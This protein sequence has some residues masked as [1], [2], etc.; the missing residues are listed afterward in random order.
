VTPTF[1]EGNAMSASVCAAG[2]KPVRKLLGELAIFGALGDRAL[3]QIDRLLQVHHFGAGCLVVCEGHT[4][5]NVFIVESGEVE[6]LKDCSGPDTAS[7]RLAI[8]GPGACFGE[9]SLIDVMP[10]SASVRTTRPSVLLSFSNA[11]LFFIYQ[12]DLE[13]F[14]LIMM[15]LAR[16][17]SRRL[18]IADRLLAEV[19]VTE[20]EA[21]AARML[22][23]LD[24]R[25]LSA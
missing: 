19:S 13:T 24:G 4:D 23:G 7:V 17:L 14:T 16:E 15:N 2:R 12:W 3:E 9:M 20:C 10:R 22:Y 11:D 6:V 5:K 1:P 8:L 21:C 18:R 25:P